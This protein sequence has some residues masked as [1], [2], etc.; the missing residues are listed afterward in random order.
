MKTLGQAKGEASMTSQTQVR[1]RSGVRVSDDLRRKVISLTAPNRAGSVPLPSN[2]GRPGMVL[3]SDSHGAISACLELYG[4]LPSSVKYRIDLGDKV[5]RGPDPIGM[6]FLLQTLRVRRLIGNHDAMWLAAGLGIPSQ[7]IELVR[8]LMRYNEIDFLASELGVSLTPLWNYAEK[9]FPAGSH[10]I[11]VKSKT[12]PNM[13]AAAT[14]LKIIAEAKVRFPEHKDTLLNDSDMRVRN[15]LFFRDGASR[16]TSGESDVFLRLTGGEKLSNDDAAYFYR[17]V[18]GQGSLNDE[19]Q[20]V[21]DHFT[22]EF[23]GNIA[24]YNFVKW[25]VGDGDV[26]VR[27]RADQGY[28]CDIIATHATIPLD[29]NFELSPFLG[30]KGR[31]MMKGIKIRI[32]LAMEAWRQLIEGGS[33]MMMDMHKETIHS[34][35]LLP[36]TAGSP[37]YGRQMQTAAR[38]VLP[39]GSG[40]WREDKERF[41][42]HFEKLGH[43]EETLKAR[44][45][46]AASFGIA[47][48]NN[49]IIVRGHEPSP[50]GLFQV[51]AGGAVINI[52][53]GLAPKYGGRGGAMVFGSAGAA[54]L[55]YPGLQ[56]TPVPIP[57]GKM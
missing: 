57:G 25:M 51:L 18:G 46:I 32:Q 39:E 23:I 54:W 43:W 30:L 4:A 40:L 35:A 20:S 22:K 15:A 17:L 47:D 8:W 3:M 42:T 38:A 11:D 5:D 55:Q 52:D 37:I 9:Y 16:L 1:P 34:L 28:P 14:Y 21:V 27:F 2:I 29:E 19:A 49:F 45:V 36:W 53:G 12:S 33:D 56:Y 48:P 10:R 26:Y 6:N 41:F 24:F 7:S 44:Q 31:D 13:E 50:D